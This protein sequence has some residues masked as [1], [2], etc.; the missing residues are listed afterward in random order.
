MRILGIDPGYAIVG[1]AVVDY[2][3]NRFALQEAG[4]VT[5]EAALPLEERVLLI[6]QQLCV[7]LDRVR[8][9]VMAIEQLFFTTNQKTVI[10]VAQARGV[11]LLA[12]AQRGVP[13]YEYTPLQVKSSVT[14][15][16]KA[17]KRQV[18]E[19]TRRLLGLDKLPKPDDVA[20]AMAVA[21]CHGHSAGSGLSAGGRHTGARAEKGRVPGFSADVLA[22]NP[23]LAAQL[24]QCDK[25]HP[26]RRG[27]Q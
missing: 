14:G 19:M 10:W 9:D 1:C 15:Y 4:A 20:D 5:T 8:P 23:A 27:G 3:K 18:M 7:L 21:I 16:G 12:A 26:G 2:E 13:I 22:R 6:Y 25:K 17:E 11:V 24:A